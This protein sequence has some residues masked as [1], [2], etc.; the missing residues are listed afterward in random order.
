MPIAI[1]VAVALVYLPGLAGPFV[2]DDHVNLLPIWNWLDGRTQAWSAIFEN[3]SGPTGRPLAYLSLMANAAAGGT[4]PFGFKAF[5]LLLHLAAA[6]LAALVARGAV[7]ADR[8]SWP[9]G[10]AL[11]AVAAWAVHPMHASSVLYVV[12]RMA[13]MG[14]IA[15]FA[16]VAIYLRARVVLETDARTG[17]LYLFAAIPLVVAAGL[18]AKETAVL[19][20]LL[21]GAAELTLFAGA[22]RRREIRVFFALF[23]WLPLAAGILVAMNEPQRLLAPFAGRE[24]SLEQRLLTEPRVLAEYA[25][26]T[27]WPFDLGLYRDGYRASTGL[28]SP[29]STA[30]AML[31][32][33]VAAAA[34]WI[35]RKQ[36]PV[37]CFGIFWFLFAHALEAGPVSLELYFEHRNYLPAF[38]LML[39]IAALAAPYAKRFGRIGFAA[40][41]ALSLGLGGLTL[42]R[43]MAWSDLD[44]LLA[45][46]GPPAGELSRRLQVD[47]AIRAF[48]TGNAAD[49]E[50]ALAALDDGAPGDAAAAALWRAVFACDAG[51]T[52][53]PA[54][55]DGL[56]RHLPPVATHGHV[57]WLGLL[58]RRV[59]AQRCRGLEPARLAGV[60]DAWLAR[61]PGIPAHSRAQLLALREGLNSSGATR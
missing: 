39:A 40:G 3:R 31:L 59:G 9:H 22:P 27:L 21:C 12:Q 32:W 46:E 57:S 30:W 43:S 20:P 7:R 11:A 49:R 17:R 34:A 56:Q 52:M 54:M 13:V 60:I 50:H 18:M 37:F 4:S 48:E 44:T 6:A 15:Q 47:R 26:R 36:R 41:I 25:G 61:I 16:A 1:L 51:E 42:A 2:L 28:F 29:M 55:L 24:F 45:S 58:A 35:A 53:S 33:I 10:L 38:G 14:A 23:L 5:N 19:A 8:R